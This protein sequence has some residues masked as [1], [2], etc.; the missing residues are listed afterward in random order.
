MEFKAPA[1]FAAQMGMEI[2]AF[3]FDPRDEPDTTLTA[4]CLA[5]PAVWWTHDA[6]G[7]SVIRERAEL[8]ERIF[9]HIVS[10]EFDDPDVAEYMGKW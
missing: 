3:G 8:H 10:V 6:D 2:A 5:C 4:R 9:G 7:W 1:N